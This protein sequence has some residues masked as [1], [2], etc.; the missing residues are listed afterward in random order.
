MQQ[1]FA[2]CRIVELSSTG[3]LFSYN[4]EFMCDVGIM[5]AVSPIC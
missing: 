1:V 2:E 3:A 5:Q 4:V